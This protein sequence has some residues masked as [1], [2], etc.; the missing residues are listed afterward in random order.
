MSAKFNIIKSIKS[1]LTRKLVLVSLLAAFLPVVSWGVFFYSLSMRNVEK[2]YLNSITNNLKQVKYNLISQVNACKQSVLSFVGDN[3]LVDF[4]EYGT[5]EDYTLVNIV[6]N[7]IVTRLRNVRMN[8]TIFDTVRLIHSNERIPEVFDFLYY[9]PSIKEQQWKDYLMSLSIMNHEGKQENYYIDVKHKRKNYMSFDGDSPLNYDVFSLYY[10]VNSKYDLETIGIFEI[11]IREEEFLKPIKEIVMPKDIVINLMT[12]DNIIIY[13]NNRDFKG[14]GTN[15]IKDTQSESMVNIDGSEYFVASL[16]IRELN[17]W[18][19][20]YTPK[21]VIYQS[22]SYKALIF[23]GIFAVLVIITSISFLVFKMILANLNKL[24][25][26]MHAIKHGDLNARVD[27]KSN[28]E[29]GELGVEFNEMAQKITELLK[30]VEDSGKAEKEAIYK[31]LESQI[32]PHFICNALDTIRMTAETQNNRQI[33]DA[34][35]L[36]CSYFMYNIYRRS[37]DV[38]LAE[39]LKNVTDYLDINNLIRSEKIEYVIKVSNDI[40]GHLDDY[41]IIKFSLQPI[42]ENAVKHGFKNKRSKCLIIIAVSCIN[43]MLHISIEDNGQGINRERLKE[44]DGLLDLNNSN[45]AEQKKSGKHLSGIGL[46]NIK[47]RL[48]IDYG[49]QYKFNIT[50]YEEIGTKVD[51]EI[52]AYKEELS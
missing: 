16:F 28:D 23:F 31:T 39:E 30:K 52:P 29:V 26:T 20:Q 36:I 41:Y 24:T 22:N 17:C 14:L 35:E 50:S 6:N 40:R 48:D 49:L 46:R 38:T 47:Q 32:S 37:K 45:I 9:D 21:G 15:E 4:L 42:I 7:S 2:E 51:L 43:G 8:S 34:V 25:K 27:V 10:P 3:Y 18:L 11:S 1:S 19:V 5:N 12:S 13:T 44:V 33:A